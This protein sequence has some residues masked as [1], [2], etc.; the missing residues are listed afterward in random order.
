MCYTKLPNCTPLCAPFHIACILPKAVIEFCLKVLT[1]FTFLFLFLM[2]FLNFLLRLS[3]GN[4]V[5]FYILTSNGGSVI[6]SVGGGGSAQWVN[7]ESGAIFA[8]L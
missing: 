5:S 6:G 4:S 2:F 3:S 1:S 8:N 7:S